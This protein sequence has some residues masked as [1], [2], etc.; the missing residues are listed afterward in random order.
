[1]TIGEYLGHGNCNHHSGSGD[2]GEADVGGISPRT[3]AVMCW[4]HPS[5]PLEVY[6]NTCNLAA[7]LECA[8]KLHNGHVIADLTSVRAAQHPKLVALV[9][10][11]QGAYTIARAWR[12]V[13]SV[14]VVFLSRPPSKTLGTSSPSF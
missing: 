13:S 12:M 5:K 11:V 14:L 7:C 8:L 10:K 9:E 4:R 1:M 2:G 3:P 6:C